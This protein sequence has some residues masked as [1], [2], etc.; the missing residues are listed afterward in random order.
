MPPELTPLLTALEQG[1]NGV[2]ILVLAFMV[3]KQF[4]LDRALK[5]FAERLAKLE[6]YINA[7]D[8]STATFPVGS[9]KR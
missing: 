7:K 4:D 1:G 9:S 6:G 8:S 2:I 3:K 5:Q